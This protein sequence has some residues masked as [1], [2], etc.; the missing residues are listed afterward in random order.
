MEFVTIMAFA[1]PPI[2]FLATTSSSKWSTMISS[3][4]ADCASWRSTFPELFLGPLLV[5]LG[6]S[7]ISLKRW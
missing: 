7:L 5:E 6:S 2:F 3:L 4:L 1:F